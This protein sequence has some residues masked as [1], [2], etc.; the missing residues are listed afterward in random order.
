MKM[1]SAMPAAENMR[2]LPH[3]LV[4]EERK[5]LTV[6]GILSI[7]SYDAFTVTLETSGGTL[8]IGGEGLTVSELSVQTGEVKIGG[9]IEYI[10]YTVRHE[11]QGSFLKRLVR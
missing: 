7:V 5:R 2:Q 11:K 3:T 6:T 10:Q 1:Q 9:A 8:A 4:L